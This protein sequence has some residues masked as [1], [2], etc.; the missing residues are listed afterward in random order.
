MWW[1]AVS[2]GCVATLLQ[3]VRFKLSQKQLQKKRWK[4]LRTSWRR[5]VVS[6]QHLESD[7]APVNM[8]DRTRMTWMERYSQPITRF[9]CSKLLSVAN[10]CWR[11]CTIWR[12]CHRSCEVCANYVL[13]GTHAY[14]CTISSLSTNMQ[15]SDLHHHV[16]LCK[17]I[18]FVMLW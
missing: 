2:F 15:Y 1:V 18:I 8:F 9:H 6:V 4:T 5:C 14:R 16:E 7:R 11:V 13:G 3:H 12:R 10:V 17:N